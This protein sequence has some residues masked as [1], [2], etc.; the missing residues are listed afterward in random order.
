MDQAQGG[1]Q[2]R[3]PGEQA[4]IRDHRRRRGP[5]RRLG[6]RDARRVGLP[7][8]MLRFSRQPPPRP[9]HCRPGR[10]QRR[11]ELSE[12]RGQRL[13]AL[14]RHHQRGRFPL[15]RGQRAPLG[16]GVGQHHRP[17]CGAG[18]A[19][20]PRIRRPAR[21]PLL[22]WRAG[23]AHVLRPRPDRS[24]A[25]ARRVLRPLPHD[26]RRR[27][28]DVHPFGNAGSRGRRWPRQGHHRP[29]PRHGRDHPPC[30]GRGGAG[31]GRLWQRLQPLHLRAQLQRHRHLA[32][33][34]AR[35]LFR[36]SLLH[37]DSSDLHP[38]HRRLPVEAHPDVGVAP[39]RRPHL[40]PE[41]EGGPAQEP[42]RHPRGGPRLLPRAHVSGLRQ[43]RPARH[44]VARGEAGV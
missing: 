44:R 3:Q 35:R 42:Q 30:G 7:G 22:R 11:Q 20:R 24:A 26:R 1:D 5:G 16:R 19:V 25:A 23:V 18:R 14:L 36:Q 32:G 10:H 43:P 15:P 27:R 13:P 8:E 12:R 4:E 37:P 40:G 34:Q 9:L 21:Q 33:L 28:D 31:H 29:Q 2:T 41:E 17:V 6:G 39:Q 38:G